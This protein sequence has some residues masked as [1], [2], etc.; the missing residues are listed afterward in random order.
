MNWYLIAADALLILHGMFVIFVV[1]GLGLVVIGGLRQWQWVRNPWFRLAHLAA[2][3][4]VVLQS[5]AGQICPLTTWEMA[6]RE[7]AGQQATRAALSVTG[8]GSCSITMHR[9]GY[10][11]SATRSLVCLCSLAGAGCDHTASS[12]QTGTELPGSARQSS[13]EPSAVHPWLPLQNLGTIFRKQ[14][15][16][17]PREDDSP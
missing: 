6:L 1:A 14:P 3:G 8:W 9:C 5:W 15:T 10:L 12:D 17:S 13:I 16:H 7:R 4:I 11:A 2:I